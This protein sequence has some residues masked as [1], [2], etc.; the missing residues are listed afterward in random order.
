MQVGIQKVFIECLTYW[1]LKI[2]DLFINRLALK[3]IFIDILKIR[4]YFVYENIYVYTYIKSE[5]SSAQNHDAHLRTCHLVKGIKTLP[6]IR[7]PHLPAPPSPALPG[8]LAR[9]VT[10]AN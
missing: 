10:S 6:A 4:E 1:A 5:V 7:K 3:S 8:P 9:C 2:F